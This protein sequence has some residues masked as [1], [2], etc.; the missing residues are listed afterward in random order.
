MAVSSG[1]LSVG[2]AALGVMMARCGA[3]FL[4]VVA[5]SPE[6]QRTATRMVDIG[7]GMEF[8]CLHTPQ[9]CESGANENVL[10][11]HGWPDRK[12]FFKSLMNDLADNGFCGLAC[13]MHGYSPG[14]SPANK[15]RYASDLLRDDAFEI[16]RKAGFS[17]FHLIGHDHGCVLGWRMA[18]SPAQADRDMVQSYVA[19]SL[20]HPDV[21]SKAL[22][23]AEAVED[24]QVSS[25]Y[26]SLFMQP[27]SANLM[28]VP[29]KTLFDSFKCDRYGTC[30]ESPEDFQKTLYWYNGILEGSAKMSMPPDFDLHTIIH[31]SSPGKGWATAIR[32]LHPDLKGQGIAQEVP[33]GNINVPTLYVCGSKDTALLCGAD[34]ALK[35]ED[36]CKAGYQYLEVECGHWLTA[37][38]DAAETKKVHDGI[39][40]HLA[41]HPY[42]HA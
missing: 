31:S 11:I 25:Q 14:A 18:A 19:M 42:S 35:T 4:P 33:A 21:F 6:P 26:F 38:D 34:W 15:S 40:A 5:A 29:G 1:L 9:T 24:Q 30:F 28:H 32:A 41:K 22:F 8:T 2:V 12:E 16:A 36:C 3:D 37:C 39:L 7:G 20:P 13:D 27:N 10:M 23:G 17:K